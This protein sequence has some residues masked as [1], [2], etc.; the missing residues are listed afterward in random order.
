MRVFKE[1]WGKRGIFFVPSGCAALCRRT[2]PPSPAGR[3]S[4]IVISEFFEMYSAPLEK[5]SM[6]GENLIEKRHGGRVTIKWDC[7]L[8]FGATA[9][10]LANDLVLKSR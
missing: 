2:L 9:G 7:L 6:R 1:A 4:F 3:V 10:K 8:L 5:L